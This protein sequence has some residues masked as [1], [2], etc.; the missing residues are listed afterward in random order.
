M[1]V[2][3]GCA[4][5]SPLLSVILLTGL[6][7]ATASGPLSGQV[8]PQIVV[9]LS[10]DTVEM[11]SVFELLVQ[12][13][14][15]DGSVLRFPDSLPATATMESAAPARSASMES[16]DGRIV[17][18]LSYPMMPFGTGDVTIPG[19]DLTLL[20][21]EGRGEE[22]GDLVRLPERTVWVAP[23]L[24]VEDLARPIEPGGPADVVGGDWSRSALALMLVCSSVFA[25]ALVSVTQGWLAP[26]AADGRP[27]PPTLEEARARALR[28]MDELLADGLPAAGQQREFYTRTTSVVRRYARRVDERF[29]PSLTSSELVASLGATRP[30]DLGNLPEEMCAAEA[31]KFGRRR[32][33]AASVER[34]WKI[35]RSWI[36]A[37]PDAPS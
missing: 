6:A 16:A 7:L 2:G 17:W 4:R 28:E 31:V 14:V 27:V 34:H 5:R 24:T 11:G 25:L 8:S 20:S 21:A 26:V 35:L 15:P 12:V 13:F 22:S 19:F 37:S 1:R 30:Q 18:T 3:M 36:S 9:T 23:V 33:D 29:A 32:P 10:A